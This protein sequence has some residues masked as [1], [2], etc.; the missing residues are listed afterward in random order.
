MAIGI[1]RFVFVP[2]SVATVPPAGLIEH[3]KDSWW[4]VHPECGLAFYGPR[5]MAPQCNR[6]ESITRRISAKYPWAEVRFYP[7]VFR[8]I[9]PS[10]YQ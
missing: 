1:D 2:E 4:A 3:I 8:R 5:A 10:D 6:D 9:N 7:S